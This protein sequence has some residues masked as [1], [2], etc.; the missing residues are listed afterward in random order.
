LGRYKRGDIQG[1]VRNA[2]HA[3]G[4]ERNSETLFFLGF[5]LAEIGKMDEARVFADEALE[6]DPL[7][8]TIH[9]ARSVV[10][11]FEGRFDAALSRF[12]NWT[13]EMTD[14]AFSQWWFG[15]ALA[16]AGKVDEAIAAFERG[17]QSSSG[18]FTE[19]CE[20]GARSF[21]GERENARTWFES[22]EGLQQAAKSDE[23]YPRYLAVCFAYIKEYDLALQCLEHAI[24]WGFTNHRFLSEYDHFLAPLRGDPR[25][26]A[27][28]ERAREKQR[29]FEV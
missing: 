25:F 11:L 18:L 6:R 15:Q 4:L 7:T 28:M 22:K 17:A 20:M 2:R 14:P 13:K 23:Y 10:D 27:L 8:W 19:L 5:S 24:G 26:E 12:R 9:L 3:V 1:F 16:Y 21:R 29:A